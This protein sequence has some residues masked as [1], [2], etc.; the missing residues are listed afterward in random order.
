MNRLYEK[1]QDKIK[2]LRSLRYRVHTMWEC[3]FNRLK[4]CD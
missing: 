2:S 1:T 3:V 4:K